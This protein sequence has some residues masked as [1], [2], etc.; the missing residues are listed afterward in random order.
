M[1]KTGDKGFGDGVHVDVNSNIN[2][3]RNGK[4]NADAEAFYGGGGGLELGG[5]SF[6]R[7]FVETFFEGILAESS[8]GSG[9]GGGDGRGGG[10][11][12]PYPSSYTSSA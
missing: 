1:E 8:Y 5:R 2:I 7:G 12:L 4:S 3:E 9:K 6:E 11:N 10:P